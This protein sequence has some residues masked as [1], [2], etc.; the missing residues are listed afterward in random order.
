MLSELLITNPA[1]KN[2]NL[3]D[4]IFEG[5]NRGVSSI[6]VPYV[7]IPLV[8]QIYSAQHYTAIVGHPYGVDSLEVKIHQLMEAGKKGANVINYLPNAFDIH[9]LEYKKVSKEYRI[10]IEVAKDYGAK[11]VA[12][13]EQRMESLSV[14]LMM[15]RVL[16]QAGIEG[17]VLATGDICSYPADA[18]LNCYKIKQETDLDITVTNYRWSDKQKEQLISAGCSTARFKNF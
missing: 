2:N 17:I 7:L 5:V 6:V 15:A 12:V 11:L 13:I 18:I 8:N 4:L 10:L 1:I 14:N 16:R 3:Q 9:N